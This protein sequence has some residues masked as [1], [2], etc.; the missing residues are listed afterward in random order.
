LSASRNAATWSLR[1]ITI[2]SQ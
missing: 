2:S 1:F